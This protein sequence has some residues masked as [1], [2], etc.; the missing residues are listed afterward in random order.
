MKVTCSHI[1]NSLPFTT[2]NQG[3]CPKCVFHMPHSSLPLHDHKVNYLN[4]V[5]RGID[6]GRM[7]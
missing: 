6:G 5:R 7:E 1:Y 3:D 2:V 4:T